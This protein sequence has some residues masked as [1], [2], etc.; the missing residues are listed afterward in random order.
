MGLS[1]FVPRLG[2]SV[3]RLR[4][5]CS[6]CF[7]R[8]WGFDQTAAPLQR[9]AEMLRPQLPQFRRL[10]AA[11]L[12]PPPPRSPPTAARV[13]P[14][15]LRRF[16]APRRSAPAL[17]RPPFR[18]GRFLSGRG[19]ADPFLP[20]GLPFGPSPEQRGASCRGTA[21]LLGGEAERAGKRAPPRARPRKA[22]RGD[23]LKGGLKKLRRPGRAGPVRPRG[24]GG[25]PRRGCRRRPPVRR[26]ARRAPAPPAARWKGTAP[27]RRRC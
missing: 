1:I 3:R 13:S 19:K 18:F 16:S 10:P 9:A 20:R 6:P 24:A 2:R 5:G 12:P 27:G 26:S 15:V 25:G 21:G 14:A 8:A 7:G 17:T 11:S 4:G 23:A 22:M